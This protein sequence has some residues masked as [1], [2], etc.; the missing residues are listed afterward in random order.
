V[1]P[2]PDSDW[3]SRY[4]SRRAVMTRMTHKKMKKVKKF[5]VFV[6]NVF[7]GGE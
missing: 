4:G 3:E 5:D 1:E 2:D 6:L 7:F